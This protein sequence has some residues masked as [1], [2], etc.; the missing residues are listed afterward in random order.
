MS[1]AP[2]LGINGDCAVAGG[3]VVGG[4]RGAAEDVGWDNLL[5]KVSTDADG[6]VVNLAGFN[7][8]DYRVFG[9]TRCGD[10]TDGTGTYAATCNSWSSGYFTAAAVP[11]PA[12]LW[13]LGSALG[14]LGIR[15]IRNRK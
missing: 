5:L 10:N 9:V 15:R 1:Y 2:Y 7:V 14:A 6:N 12:T 4:V 8:D 11:A 3:C 13:L